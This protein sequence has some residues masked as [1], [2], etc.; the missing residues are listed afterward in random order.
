MFR[1][2]F[3]TPLLFAIFAVLLS[4]SG[5]LAQIVPGTVKVE[6]VSGLEADGTTAKAGATLSYQ[7][8]TSGVPPEAF[9]QGEVRAGIPGMGGSRGYIEQLFPIQPL[10]ALSGSYVIPSF[11]EGHPFFLAVYICY[12]ESCGGSTNFMNGGSSPSIQV[13][14][15]V[16]DTITTTTVSS[17]TVT[18]T[19]A[20]TSEPTTIWY[21][22]GRCL[23]QTTTTL[24]TTLAPVTVT[25]PQTTA[26]PVA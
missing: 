14:G 21:E 6:I 7:V 4:V 20:P 16:N 9:M 3:I 24:Y 22:D 17:F 12:Q 2:R 23:V 15:N 11:F 25:A 18:S 10:S 5:S 8:S 19:S 13:V 26:T 1:S